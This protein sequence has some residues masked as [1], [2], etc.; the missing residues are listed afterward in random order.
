MRDRLILLGTKG[1]PSVWSY[2]PSPSANVLVYRGIAN[3]I[4]AGYGATF[5][6]IEAGVPLHAIGRIFITHHHS[7]HNIDLGPMLYAAWANGLR[8]SVDAYGPAG[9]IEHLAYF[10]KANRF[11][12]ETRIAD[13]GSI[14]L[15]TLVTPH[16]YREG[17]VFEAPDL[18]VTALRN[19]HPPIAESYALKFRFGGKTVVFSG[20]TAYFPPLGEFARGA[21]YLI[22]EVMYGPAIDA[23]ASRFQNAAKLLAHLKASHTLA[24]DVGRIATAAGVKN[25]VLNHFVPGGDNT[26]GPEMWIEAVRT[27]FSGT[28]VVGADLLEL[29]I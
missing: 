21:D 5:K 17:A 20:D 4:D 16:E 7:D 10:W 9:L 13:E 19:R 25:L 29:E 8:T 27:T 15:R 24:E 18:K 6:L 3:V 12:I 26:I 11:D 14:D 28:I 22:H 23:L 1:G 2:K